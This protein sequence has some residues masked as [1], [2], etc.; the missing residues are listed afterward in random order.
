[1]L[2]ILLKNICWHDN[3]LCNRAIL[4]KLAL[5]ATSMKLNPHSITL[6]ISASI[7]ALLLTVG[8]NNL[9]VADNAAAL[10]DA[11]KTSDKVPEVKVAATNEASPSVKTSAD[12]DFKKLDANKDGKISL[13]EAV[14]DKSLANQFDA[15]D[16]NHDGMVSI[17]EY[18]SYKSALA[19][20][21]TGMSPTTTTN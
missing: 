6:P 4:F 14:K 19:A 2:L 12:E 5:G 1:M 7:V 9:A 11:I 10:K 8:L 15:A 3:R 18:S 17:D 13:K 20:G 16:I 21:V